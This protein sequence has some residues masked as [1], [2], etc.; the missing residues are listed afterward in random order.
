MPERFI[1]LS[2]D[3]QKFAEVVDRVFTDQA[4]AKRMLREPAGAL[5]QAGYQ[6][7]TQQKDA[8][9][10]AQAIEDVSLTIPKVKPVVRI[11]T[12][13]TK[14]VVRVVT[15]GTSPVVSV[16]TNTVVAVRESRG[17]ML[18]VVPEEKTTTRGQRPERK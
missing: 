6:L 14:P 2:E 12:K 18:E 15:K 17:P 4:F 1:P 5:A 10:R 8:I 3:E 13:G 9:K 7:T 11:L 16:V